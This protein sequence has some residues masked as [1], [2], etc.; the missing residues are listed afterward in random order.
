[1]RIIIAGGRDFNDY[2]LMV[3]SFSLMIQKLID[4]GFITRPI[5]KENIEI[6]S[7]TCGG[8]DNHGEKL[9]VRHQFMLTQMPAAWKQYGKKAGYIRNVEMARYAVEDK[10]V[11]LAFWDGKSRGT[12]HMIDIAKEY[13]LKGFVVSY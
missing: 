6:V 5:L 8:A 3:K 9:A 12:K 2:E 4:S 13:N 1:M 10:G 11:L 7:G